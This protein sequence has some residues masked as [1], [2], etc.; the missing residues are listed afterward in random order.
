MPLVCIMQ[1]VIWPC[2]EKISITFCLLKFRG[3][4]VT[5]ME[6]AGVNNTVGPLTGTKYFGGI[7]FSSLLGIGM[8]NAASRSASL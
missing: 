3:I 2:L 6:F 7:L 4:S 5:L 8:F 1:R